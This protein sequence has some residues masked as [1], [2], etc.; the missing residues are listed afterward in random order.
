MAVFFDKDEENQRQAEMLASRVKKRFKHLSKRYK[1]QKLD[2]F[3]L[4]DW[5]IPEIRAVV[6]WYAGHLVIA[7]YTRTQSTPEWLPTMAREVA[8]VLGVPSHKVHLKERKAG[9]HNR[10]DEYSQLDEIDE[11][12][13][14]SERD[15]TFL[16]NPSDYLDTGLFS[17]HRNTREM[18]RKEANGK[19]F[20]N[21]FAYTGT[22]SCYAARGGAKSTTTVDRSEMATQ[23]TR[24]NM[25]KNGIPKEGNVIEKKDTFFFLAAAK[26]ADRKFDLAVVDPPSFYT[27]H[28]KTEHFDI[29]E[30]HPKLLEQVIELMRDNSVIYFSTNHQNFEPYFDDLKIKN[31]VE[32][33][34]KTI[35]E[36]YI[37]KRKK[38]HRCWRIE[39]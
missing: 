27:N 1:K 37:S 33:T 14:V 21:L 20:L 30:D 36:D 2:V 25:N 16:V 9:Y 4:Y 8:K 39:V 3:R 17:D 5:D 38:I 31:A 6:D 26:R 7:E 32:I 22:F 23:W 19:D 34:D 10:G 18:V 35:P 13:E 29:S 11:K 28:R 24:E 12:I 15:F